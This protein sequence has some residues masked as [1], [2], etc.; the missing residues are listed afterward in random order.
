MYELQKACLKLH[1][2]KRILVTV[3]ARPVLYTKSWIVVC[4]VVHNNPIV[5][6][7]LTSC[8]AGRSSFG[9]KFANPSDT[10]MSA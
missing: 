5:S 7:G 9:I 6:R 4:C 1:F 10:T 2:F 8:D 3:L